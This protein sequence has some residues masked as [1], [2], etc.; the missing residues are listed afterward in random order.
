MAAEA[1]DTLSAG[2]TGTGLLALGVYLAAEGLVRG[3]GGDD[4]DKRKMEEMMGHQAYAL[5]LPD[6]TSA[7][8]DWMAPEALPFFVG[9]N[10]WEN[11]QGG[12]EQL[13][14]SSVLDSVSTISEPLLEM[15]CLQSLNDVFDSVS[16][17]SDGGLE[18]LPAA[19][20]SAATSYLTQA[21]PTV[22]GQAERTGEDK[23]YTTFTEK[24]AFLTP[25]MQYTIGKAS[26]KIPGWDFQQI[27]YIDAWGRT[28]PSGNTA[29]RAFQNFL[30]PAYTSSIQTS[31]MEKE[32][33]RLYE[34]TG[35][36]AVFP[37]RADKKVTAG[38]ETKQ[39]TADEYVTY[40]VAK[41]QESR[42]MLEDLVRSSEY[43]TM[44]DAEKAAAVKNVYDLANQTA[45]EK[46]ST[47]EPQQWVENAVEAERKY[48]ISR[49]T[50]AALRAMTA[51]IEGLKDKDGETIQDSKG[52]Q[53]MEVIYNTPGLNDSQ[54]AAMAEYLG[55]G[56]KVRKLNKAA[57]TEK[58]ERL[59]KKSGN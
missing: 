56:K 23:R 58:L 27:P 39:L 52:L 3:H 4:D 55:V 53:I 36:A 31:G 32:L 57:V 15:S 40:A 22:L 45:K 10:L 26:A 44:S 34:S 29:A 48:R 30:N 19:L 9:V 8:L 47:Y 5:E 24:N 41:G 18:G 54:R 1:I 46:V 35:E 21:L 59:R 25:D 14:L 6:G 37:D 49:E 42:R 20:S 50:Y 28:E 51:G 11:T 38:G 16:N 7:T 17:V 33:L 43:K 13:T 2:L 12:K